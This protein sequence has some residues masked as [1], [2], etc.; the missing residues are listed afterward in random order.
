[1]ANVAGVSA[2]K[3]SQQLTAI[4]NNFDNGTKSLEHYADVLVKLGSE[5]A[6]SSNEISKGV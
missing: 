2:E 3:A 6:S 4:W 5:T 1:M